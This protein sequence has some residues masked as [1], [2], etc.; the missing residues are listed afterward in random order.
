MSANKDG[1]KSTENPERNINLEANR[2]D[3]K[4]SDEGISVIHRHCYPDDLNSDRHSDRSTFGVDETVLDVEH[5]FSDKAMVRADIEYVNGGT[6]ARRAGQSIIMNGR[7][8][9]R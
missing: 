2:I 9:R 6:P 7:H 5:S 1:R 3:N 8:F 4:E